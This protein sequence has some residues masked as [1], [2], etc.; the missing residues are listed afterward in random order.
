MK[1]LNVRDEFRCV[2]LDPG[3]PDDLEIHFQAKYLS[4]TDLSYA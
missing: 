2:V 1:V 3:D 4:Y